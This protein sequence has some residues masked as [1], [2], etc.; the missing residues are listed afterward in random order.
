VGICLNHRSLG[1]A[2]AGG[3]ISS[4]WP[5]AIWPRIQVKKLS[6]SRSEPK[7]LMVSPVNMVLGLGTFS[8]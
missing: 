4:A 3:S 6:R 7:L 5:S 8:G 1:S 2:S